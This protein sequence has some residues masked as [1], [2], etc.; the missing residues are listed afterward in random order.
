[1]IILYLCITLLIIINLFLIYFFN[2]K[3]IKKFFFNQK[4]KSVNLSEVN[5]NFFT[6]KKY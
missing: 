6:I 1:M 4:I 2:K 3:K 5:E